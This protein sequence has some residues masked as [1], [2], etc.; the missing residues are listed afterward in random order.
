MKTNIALTETPVTGVT[1]AI[2]RPFTIEE[3]L[4]APLL[5]TDTITGSVSCGGC[6]ESAGDS[7]EISHR[8]C[9]SYIGGGG[10]NGYP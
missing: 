10:C 2:C 6:G 7:D 9:C 3:R 4:A 8:V 5:I 1:C